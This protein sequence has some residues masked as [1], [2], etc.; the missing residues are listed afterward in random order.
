MVQNDVPFAPT[1]NPGIQTMINALNK[2]APGEATASTYG[3]NDVYS[4]VS[5]LL[6]TAAAKAANL[7][8]NATPAQVKA[9]LYALHNETLGGMAPP[10]NFA[11]NGKGHEISCSF[12]QGVSNNQFVMPQGQTLNCAPQAAIAS[13]LGGS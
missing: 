2:Y 13:M 8:D 6:F 3:E 10:L 12:V 4:W 11:N 9:G 5:G 7:G 1:S